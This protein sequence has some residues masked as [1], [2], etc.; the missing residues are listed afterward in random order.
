M[1]WRFVVIC[2]AA[3]I[4]EQA[5]AIA[6]DLPQYE[7]MGFP[8]TPLQM[9]VLDSAKVQEQPPATAL[10]MNDMPA[11]PAQLAILTP[12]SRMAQQKTVTTKLTV[13]AASATV[14]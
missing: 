10:T 1:N 13:N 12:R 4:L 5:G 3:L 8:I 14:R 6:G 11:S 9:S 2:A 7:V